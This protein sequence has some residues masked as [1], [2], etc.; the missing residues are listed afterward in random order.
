MAKRRTKIVSED[1]RR[2]C[3]EQAIRWP[4]VA[5]SH[6]G[7]YGGMSVSRSEIDADIIGRAQK[8]FDWINK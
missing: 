2:W 5:D 1:T 7:A 3:I 4:R 8:I 6:S